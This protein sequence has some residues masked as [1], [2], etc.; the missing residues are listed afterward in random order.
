MTQLERR[1]VEAGRMGF[2]RA[3]VGQAVGR[4]GGKLAVPGISIAT[5]P[6]IDSL[7]GSFAA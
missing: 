6:H 1:L 5:I 7:A 4:S 3:V 2:T